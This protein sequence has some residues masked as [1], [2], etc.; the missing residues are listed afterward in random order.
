M[1]S[2]PKQG[3]TVVR[4]TQ[5]EMDAFRREMDWNSFEKLVLRPLL[6]LHL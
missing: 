6:F 3:L 4:V 1:K 2:S 5:E